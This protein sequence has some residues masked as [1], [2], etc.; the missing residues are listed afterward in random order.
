MSD[1]ARKYNSG[2]QGA[3]SNL[4]TRQAQAPSIPGKNG[5][6][7]FDGEASG[8][9]IDRK[10]AVVTSPKAQN[11]ALRQSAALRQNNLTGIWEVP[12]GAQAARARAML[13]KLGIENINVRI[14][15]R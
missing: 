12:D 8:T 13:T 11:Q 9:L 6:V 14:V 3:R 15:P 5:P 7:R 10:L 2:A 4:V 1:E